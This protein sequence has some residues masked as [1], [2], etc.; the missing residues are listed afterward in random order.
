MAD[1][2]GVA[3][4]PARAIQGEGGDQAVRIVHGPAF[5]LLAEL[6]AFTSGP[7]RASLESGKPWIRETRRLAG[8]E[9]IARASTHTLST[10]AGLTTFAPEM[11]DEVAIDDFLERLAGLD[12]ER[13]RRRL[14]GADS[15]MYRDALDD[16]LISRAASGDAPARARVHAVI[17]D[18][19]ATR[20]SVDRLL[21]AAA[22]D[23]RRDLGDVLARWRDR[24]FPRWGPDA[25]AAVRR[26][27]T[28]K[29][30]LL[31]RT[32][33]AE[34]VSVATAGLAFQPAEWVRQIVIVPVVALRPF[35]VPV[36]FEATQM[37]LVSVADESLDPE[38]RASNRLAR[39]AAALGDPVRLRTLHELARD[40][41]LTASELADRV[42]VERTSLHHHL[43]LLR[44]AGLLAIEDPG[45]G[46]WHYRVR[47][48]RID[49]LGAS[50]QAYLDDGP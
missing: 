2:R 25:V 9:L 5:E 41:G 17:S 27:V 3:T 45:D 40:E 43:G 4:V 48:D 22:G 8:P 28:A 35:V 42:G 50:L 13:I 19:R 39:L 47:R 10:Y 37:F 30:E 26:D 21:R 23:L 20:R 34:L 29:A 16:A 12:P 18:D 11:G 46:S 49:E 1:N 15:P 7:A 31:A 36:D 32:S 38:G 44:S 6:A 24:V 33:P 14:I